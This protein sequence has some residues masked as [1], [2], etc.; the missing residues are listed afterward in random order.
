MLGYGCSIAVGIGVPIPIL[1]EE[2]ARFTGVSDDE[3][4]TQVI[5]YGNDYPKGEATSLG[6]VSYADLKSGTI[7]LNGQ[8][9]PTVPISSYVR[10]LEIAHLL[11]TWIEKREFLLT[12]PQNMLPTAAASPSR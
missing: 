7:R 8:D 6:R 4:F 5:D 12:E 2:I 3:I 9:I 10:A 11:K 1:N